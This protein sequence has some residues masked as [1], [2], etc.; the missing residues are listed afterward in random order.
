MLS[1]TPDGS[2]VA[3][4]VAGPFFNARVN[5]PNFNRYIVTLA[6]DVMTGA[7]AGVGVGAGVGLGVGVGTGV[8]VGVGDG[9]FILTEISVL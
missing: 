1:V 4:N 2:P 6:G 7:S 5:E 3:L 9:V 8:G